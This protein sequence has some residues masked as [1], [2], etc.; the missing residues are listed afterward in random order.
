MTKRNIIGYYINKELKV[1]IKGFIELTDLDDRVFKL[2]WRVYYENDNNLA[3]KG[4]AFFHGSKPPSIDEMFEKGI[5]DL[6]KFR[7]E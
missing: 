7:I 3:G 1:P 5:E 6:Q 4:R 2:I